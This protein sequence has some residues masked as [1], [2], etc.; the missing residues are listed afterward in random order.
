MAWDINAISRLKTDDINI[1]RHTI[2]GLKVVRLGDGGSESYIVNSEETVEFQLA[3][4]DLFEN[5]SSYSTLH[6]AHGVLSAKLAT[7]PFQLDLI[8]LAAI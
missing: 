4:D 5:L 1:A 7:R 2:S 3:I 8:V 6:K